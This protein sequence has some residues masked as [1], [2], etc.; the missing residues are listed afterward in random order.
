[1]LYDKAKA[2]HV[3]VINSRS[4]I[5]ISLLIS[6]LISQASYSWRNVIDGNFKQKSSIN[7]AEYCQFH[8]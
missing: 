7:F 2:T 5:I 3:C 6:I 8:R 4:F 1:M